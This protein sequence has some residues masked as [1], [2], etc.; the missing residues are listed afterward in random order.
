[1]FVFFAAEVETKRQADGLGPRL[2]RSSVAVGWK[3]HKFKGPSCSEGDTRRDRTSKCRKHAGQRKEPK[4]RHRNASTA[5]VQKFISLQKKGQKAAANVGQKPGAHV[6]LS[7]GATT[8]KFIVDGAASPVHSSRARQCLGKCPCLCHP[9]TRHLRTTLRMSRFMMF[10]KGYVAEV[11][12]LL[13][14]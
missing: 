12:C 4:L 11:R 14:Q 13:S 6:F 5:R 2:T 10:W 8:L 9:T 1:M 3:N 7:D